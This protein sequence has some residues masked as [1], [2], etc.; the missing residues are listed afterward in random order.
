V[1]DP[2]VD[3]SLVKYVE[4][5]EHV[6]KALQE[7]GPG[8]ARF[9]P[10]LIDR[11]RTTLLDSRA[12]TRVEVLIVRLLEGIGLSGETA[13]AELMPSLP[14]PGRARLA[15]AW[16]EVKPSAAP[17]VLRA[18]PGDEAK[19]L[20]AK[21]L[22]SERMED[23]CMPEAWKCWTL[24]ASLSLRAAAVILRL[25]LESRAPAWKV[26]LAA[27]TREDSGSLYGGRLAYATLVVGELDP[28]MARQAIP[29]LVKLLEQ[30]D[31]EFGSQS[32]IEE[33]LPVLA[34]VIGKV[35]DQSAAAPLEA[36]VRD[37]GSDP[38]REAA[39]QAL[40]AIQSRPQ[41]R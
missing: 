33:L 11:L 5:S 10:A 16:T 28:A 32:A 19:T 22:T 6:K 39:K 29:L 4:Y 18:M 27:L 7:M 9:Q 1:S 21:E 36:I 14:A 35:G 31:K 26:M 30:A 3:A 37:T 15:M 25:G 24:P 13:L 12:E 41:P 40:A 23:L 38:T 34:R 2:K 20:L 17:E 8:A